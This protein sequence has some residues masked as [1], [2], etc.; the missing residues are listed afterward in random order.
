[1][2]VRDGLGVRNKRTTFAAR[3]REQHAGCVRSPMSAAAGV[4]CFAEAQVW[5]LVSGSLLSPAQQ[6]SLASAPRSHSLIS[7]ISFFSY[8][9]RKIHQR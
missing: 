9:V 1:M 3:C 4:C 2:L 5:R 7:C 6:V 8:F